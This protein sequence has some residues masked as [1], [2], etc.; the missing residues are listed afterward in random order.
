M[1]VV[2]VAIV[3]ESFLPTLNGV[4]TSVCRVLDHLADTGH[5]A[6]VVCPG[7]APTA[8]RG[9]EVRT[10]RG[11]T[12]RGFRVGVPTF[13]LERILA[14]YAPQVVHAA[15]PFGHGARGLA[16]ARNLG[17]PSV[18][19][20]Q[21]DMPTY[22]AQHGGPISGGVER[23][24][25]RWLRHLHSLADITLAPSSTTLQ[26]LNDHGIPR[27]ALWGRGVDTVNYHPDRR[28]DEEVTDL[29]R[30]VAP[31]G[32]TVLGYVGRLAPE[33]EIHRLA[34][35][36]DLPNTSVVIV[37]DGPSRD[38]LERL[39]PKAHFLGFRE[40]I[41]LAQA[42]SALD[43]FVHT[44][45]HETFGQTLQEA[46]AAGLPVVAPA[47]GGP[48]D[49]VKPGV[50]G[51]LFDPEHDGALRQAVG[52]LASDESMRVRMGAS[53]RRKVEQRSWASVVD[54]LLDFYADA[55]NPAYARRVA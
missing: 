1:R 18:A 7:P 23:A 33:K 31:H 32:E 43:V 37:G 21:T 29:R 35:V 5:E 24:T 26:E 16:A 15:S 17:L 12:V 13:E 22:L 27:T 46:M 3:T 47:A 20:Y 2:R 52:G 19:V 36:A 53:G 9:F 30:C 34:E 50:T 38:R 45:C 54:Q 40:G 14:D 51:L 8:Y 48:L 41:P 4:T 39:L 6:M 42:Y 28:F 25:W 44:G 55:I 11:V 49:I 10:V